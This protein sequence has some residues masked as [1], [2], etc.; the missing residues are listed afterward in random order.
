MLQLS[1]SRTGRLEVVVPARGRHL[2]MYAAG[3]ATRGG[4]LRVAV[5]AD[6]VRRVSEL[7]G[8]QVTVIQLAPPDAAQPD[9][10]QQEAQP[11]SMQDRLA[12]NVQPPDRAGATALV[13]LARPDGTVDVAV[14]AG[15]DVP[16]TDPA[17]AGVAVALWVVCGPV[18][19][20]GDPLLPDD[21][22]TH[23]LDPLALRFCLLC[24]HHSEALD[25]TQDALV[26][27]QVCLT[28]W[29]SQ[30]ADWAESPSAPMP[31][32]Y[33]DRAMAALDD[34]LD[35]PMV[36]LLLEDLAADPEP[37]PGAKFEM[38]AHLDRVLALDLVRDVG[39]S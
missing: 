37:A 21:G 24:A 30:V 29:R 38:F 6:L 25:P 20:D 22:A 35:T 15:P 33:R 13:E 39:R 32:T 2:R 8:L 12:L 17:A 26:A 5:V 28:G 1:D 23:G 10:A 34:D 19:H 7:R 36:L 16:V 31:G 27:A 9:A 18:G 3:D 14:T 4:D 11:V